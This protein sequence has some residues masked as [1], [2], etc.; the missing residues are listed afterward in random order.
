MAGIYIHIPF[1]KQKCYYCDFYTHQNLKYV[2]EYLQA[3][4][5]EVVLRKDFF[6]NTDNQINTIYFGGGTP[7][8]LNSGQVRFL[9]DVISDN[10]TIEKKTE[11]TFEA[12][13]DDLSAGYLKKLKAVGVNRLSIGIQSFNDSYL[14]L[15]NR[16]HNGAEAQDAVKQAQDAGFDNISTDLI[17]GLPDSNITTLE[18]DLQKMAKLKIQHISAYHLTYEQKT[19]FGNYLKKGKLREIPD[20]MSYKQYVYLCKFLSMHG[21]EH[22]EISNFALNGKQ[23]VHNSNYWRNI[24]YLGLGV[25]SHSFDKENRSWNPSNLKTYIS[26]L[27]NNKLVYE[28]ENLS[29][30]DKYNDY[31]LTGIRTNWGI[32]EEY[33]LK[34]FG[35][36]LHK[37]FSDNINSFL[38]AGFFDIKEKSL[39]LKEN[40]WFQADNIVSKLMYIE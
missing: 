8:V 5:N 14:K 7:S 31:L 15:M 9:L 38:N 10:F 36:D 27:Q 19:V 29:V 17:Y 18:S 40:K 30:T 24:P 26:A 1:C 39:I 3:L 34:E 2:D 28:T 20:E 32:S 22:Y 25:A 23:S 6:K 13:P 4:A 21:F 37:H 16:R 33:I 11:I 12:N 35:K